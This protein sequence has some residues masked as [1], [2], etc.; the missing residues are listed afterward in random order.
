M[1]KVVVDLAVR[2]F[3]LLMVSGAGVARADFEV[4]FL[5]HGETTWNR[6]HILQGSVSNTV[7]TARGLEMAAQTA[8]GFKAQGVVFDRIYSSPYLRARRTAEVIA[9]RYGLRPVV[10]A[11]IREMC[12]GR[13]E[14]V[15]YGKDAWPDDNLRRFFE[16]PAAYEPQGEGAE[17]FARVQARIRDFLEHEL[18]PLDGRVTRIL[19]VAH[20][21]V[22]NS[23]VREL[24][25]SSFSDAAK[26]PIQRNC[27]VHVVTFS[28]G[29]FS[30]KEC[31]R[32]FY[33]PKR[34]E[35]MPSPR[36][37]AHRGA[38]DLTMPE[39]SR[40]AYSNAVAEA[41]DIVKLDLQC[42]KDGVI[43]MGHD[44]GLLR[45]MGWKTNIWDVSYA[46]LREK[47][48]LLPKGGFAGERI[49]RLDEALEIVRPAPE[50]WIDF[51]HF[52][53]DFVERAL[54]TFARA[55][56]DRS[57]IMVAT[58]SRPAL[59]YMSVR[60]PD[61]RRVAHVNL[62]RLPDGGWDSNAD[63]TGTLDEV[64]RGVLSFREK[65]GLFG[66]NMP[67]ISG[68]TRPQDVR[69]LSDNGLWVSL[70]FVQDADL[71]AKYRACGAA[72]FVSDHASA[73]R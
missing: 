13:Y 26:T 35:G 73:V 67:V 51:K 70:W 39:A 64:M 55:G 52:D 22:L 42:T 4:Y 27:C 47:G 31:G 34:F 3:V 43:V 50:F 15:R 41:S 44:K 71:A 20:A 56:I 37:V 72:A 6:A 7:L 53:P 28:D 12:F 21:L 60:H 48:T 61:I 45:S 63:V 18:K 54:E 1:K 40:P 32:V 23:L 9:E 14:G 49:V 10:D 33:D 57:R 65:L 30:L 46:E 68:Q 17:S 2:A 62:C 5:R 69:F 16:D 38:A 29:V 25:D 8:A 59:E 19:C 66:V 11:R 36:V 58:F 24:A